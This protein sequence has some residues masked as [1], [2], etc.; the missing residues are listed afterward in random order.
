MALYVVFVLLV[1]A[2]GAGVFGAGATITSHT[3]RGLPVRRTTELQRT[4]FPARKRFEDKPAQL[5]DEA[6]ARERARREAR[7]RD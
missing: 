6:F 1:A 4:A 5:S 2:L 7:R 3:D